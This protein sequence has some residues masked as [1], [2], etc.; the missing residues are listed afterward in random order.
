MLAP[1]Y[2]WPRSIEEVVAEA[3]DP[4]NDP[5]RLLVVPVGIPPEI[6][7]T[8]YQEVETVVV[9]SSGAK[10]VDKYISWFAAHQKA[11]HQVAPR[12]SA[13]P[14]FTRPAEV[15]NRCD[16]ATAGHTQPGTATLEIFAS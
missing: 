8:T 9:P 14:R 4:G 6:L 16:S 13:L 7:G 5:V 2:L 15:G 10:L 3:M 1:L 11:S 12:W